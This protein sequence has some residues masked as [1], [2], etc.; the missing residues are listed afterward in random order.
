MTRIIRRLLISSLILISL[1]FAGLIWF[2]QTVPSSANDSDTQVDAAIV[3]TGG[4]GR[5][6][7]G[8]KRLAEG[9]AKKLFISGVNNHATPQ[10][11]IEPALKRAS[12]DL[13]LPKAAPIELGYNATSTIGNA[14][15][16]VEWVENERVTSIRLITANYHMPRSL[17][18]FKETLP[19]HI[20]ILPDPVFPSGFHKADWWKGGESSHLLLSEYHKLIAS[21]LRHRVIAWHKSA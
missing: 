10:H 1:W 18:E 8:L 17:L 16:V 11:I 13:A 12:E 21:Y 7:L 9:K 15:E 20:T 4:Q 3:L 14:A 2:L 6:D 19:L 5:V